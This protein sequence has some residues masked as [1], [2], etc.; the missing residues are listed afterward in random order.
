M[1]QHQHLSD[2]MKV[3]YEPMV[4]TVGCRNWGFLLVAGAVMAA[5]E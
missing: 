2:T 3:E 5:Q 1:K 4:V